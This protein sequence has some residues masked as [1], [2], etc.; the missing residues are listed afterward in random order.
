LNVNCITNKGF[1]AQG[2]SA[3]EGLFLNIIYE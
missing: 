2:W 1:P 3:L